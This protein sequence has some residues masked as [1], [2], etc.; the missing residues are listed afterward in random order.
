MRSLVSF[1]AVLSLSLATAC[2]TGGASGV[3]TGARLPEEV[4]RPGDLIAVSIW[5]EPDLS[6]TVEVDPDGKVVLPKL[7]TL[8]LGGAT[9]SAV[10]AR[11][12]D[13]Y[14][15][16][17]RNPSI[18]VAVL[19]RVQVSG[20]VKTP[21]LYHVSGTMT[22]GDAIALAGGVTADGNSK[23]VELI[24]DG[25]TVV[26]DLGGGTRLADTPIRSGDQLNVPYKSWLSRNGYLAGGIISAVATIVAITVRR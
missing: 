2:A 18:Q 24:R 12:T 17:L 26:G 8:E 14:T 11:I 19:R 20:A 4:V 10:K 6:D 21:N 7:G 23:K 25:K 16:Y 13:G 5:Q 1:V 3:Q 22:V 9:P 15:T